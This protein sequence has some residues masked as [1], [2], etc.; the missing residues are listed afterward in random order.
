MD[1]VTIFGQKRAPKSLGLAWFIL[2]PIGTAAINRAHLGHAGDRDFF[3]IMGKR[4]D[5]LGELGI[6]GGYLQ[7]YLNTWQ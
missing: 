2:P 6:F 5:V 3:W 4:K 1:F 7:P